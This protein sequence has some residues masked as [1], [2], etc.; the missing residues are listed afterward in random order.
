MKA[1]E[2]I[3]LIRK[4]EGIDI[5]FKEKLPSDRDLAKQLVCFANSN[6]GK[7]IIGVDKKGN[8]KGVP[9]E[10]IDKILL[11]LDDVALR[12]C[13]PPV[14]IYPETI[15]IDGK[16]II[17]VEIPRGDNKPYFVRDGKAYVRAGSKCRPATRYEHIRLAHIAKGVNF[18]EVPI[19]GTS[20]SD[21]DI[22]YTK[23]FFE[24]HYGLKL[25]LESEIK[26]VLKNLKLLSE[27]ET[28]TVSGLLFFGVNPQKFL[29]AALIVA[30]HF[31]SEDIVTPPDDKKNIMGKVEDM[32]KSVEKF[33]YLYIK[34]SH[35]IIGFENEVRQEIPLTVLRESVVNAI[36]HRDYTV[37]APIRVFIFPDRV[38]VHTPG[39]LPNTVTL[40][41]MK[42][43]I[44][45]PRN[46]LIYSLLER[47]GLVTGVGRGI[48]SIIKTM[49]KL[50]KKAELKLIEDPSTGIVSE[51]V[52]TLYR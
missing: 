38:E 42:L 48:P 13:E 26:H 16:F 35:E 39:G 29:P 47:M 49:E 8:I 25:H 12:R 30:A 37:Q 18:D 32:L 19:P 7:L 17:I 3:N 1:D 14:V 31:P 21:I 11:K 6:G 34:E 23:H 43:G 33:F 27:E 50:G 15:Q 4:G 44:H 20:L 10:E 41:G 28:L 40:E 22:D 51:F 2:L 52:L 46:P 9:G 5:E 45:V 24:T 36:A